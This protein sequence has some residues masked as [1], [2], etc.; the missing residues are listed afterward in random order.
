[1]PA[2]NSRSVHG[3][4]YLAAA[5]TDSC[6]QEH[7]KGC[8]DINLPGVTSCLEGRFT[9]GSN[10]CFAGGASFLVVWLPSGPWFLPGSSTR[11]VRQCQICL[12]GVNTSYANII[13]KADLTADTGIPATRRDRSE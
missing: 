4:L 8:V 2:Q 7:Y 10:C 3:L 9:Q 1:M 13:L 12:D 6:Q 11:L 5:R